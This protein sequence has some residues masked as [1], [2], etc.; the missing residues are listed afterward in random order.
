VQQET[1]GPFSV[2]YAGAAELLDALPVLK[3][4]PMP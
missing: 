4:V 3:R 2:T 1:T